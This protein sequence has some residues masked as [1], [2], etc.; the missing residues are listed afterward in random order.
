MPVACSPSLPDRGRR[1]D[2]DH[3]GQQTDEQPRPASTTDT[4]AKLG[5][6]ARALRR[7]PAHT[8]KTHL[9]G[10]RLTNPV[11]RLTLTWAP[12]PRFDLAV[13][14]GRGARSHKRNAPGSRPGGVLR[15]HL[16]DRRPR[17]TDATR[18]ACVGH[19]RGVDRQSPQLLASTAVPCHLWRLEGVSENGR[20][21]RRRHRRD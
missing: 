15:F 1:R 16:P 8:T 14:D 17:Q 19:R 10:M 20:V 21:N 2:H 13:V 18:H 6:R 5:P 11:L 7:R 3:Q 4:L 12:R 9:D